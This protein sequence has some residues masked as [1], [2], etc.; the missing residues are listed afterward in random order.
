MGSH[1]PFGHL[2]HKLWPKEGSRIK[3]AVWFPT[4]KSRKSPWFP[5]VQG[6]VWHPVGKIS[7]RDITLL[8]IS[9]QSKVYIQSYGPSKLRES[10]LWEFRDSRLGVLEQNDIWLL[11]MWLGTKYNRRGMVV[12]SLESRLWWVLWVYVCM[13]FVHAPKC[14]NYALTNLLFGLY[15]FVWV[16]IACQ[17][18]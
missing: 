9:S 2:K 13:W 18:A 5:C 10:Q 14:S 6:G 7:T 16:W 11:V 8:E 4:T 1:D 17:S 3:L 15:R 12:A